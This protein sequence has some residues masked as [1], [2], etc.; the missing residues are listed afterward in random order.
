MR[1]KLRICDDHGAKKLNDIGCSFP[2]PDAA[3]LG[4]E[5]Q[6]ALEIARSTAG[7]VDS[8]RKPFESEGYRTRGWNDV[9]E[10]EVAQRVE[11]VIRSELASRT[12]ALEA[13][14]VVKFDH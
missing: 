2:I 3:I 13:E 10:T 12:T 1:S 11:R 8:V 14:P 5:L 9:F 4:H 6:H 7:D